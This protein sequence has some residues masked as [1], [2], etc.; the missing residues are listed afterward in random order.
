MGRDSESLTDSDYSDVDGHDESVDD[1]S[2]VPFRKQALFI[3][4]RMQQVLLNWVFMGASVAL[5]LDFAALQDLVHTEKGQR[6]DHFAELCNWFGV[7]SCIGWFVG[8]VLLAHWLHSV[9]AT[10]LALVGCYLKLVA[11]IFF[12]IQ[13]MTGTM[14]DP[15]YNYGAGVWWSNLT[16]IILFH[17]GNVVSCIDFF[18]QP[19]PGADKKKG[20]LYHGNLPVTGM[21]IYQ[22]ATWFL[23]ASNAMAC[24][25]NG[26]E[27]YPLVPVGKWPVILCQMAG[28]GGLLIGAIV[29]T[30]W[31]DGFRNWSHGN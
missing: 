14:N 8:F 17:S 27:G 26:A 15:A 31:C 12:N 16:G 18:L 20:W 3:P 7:V 6:P 28:G 25:F 4:H 22:L 19:P 13:P 10:R 1:S 11:A 29:F 23:V 30:I 9:G 24:T 2:R 5:L 21:W